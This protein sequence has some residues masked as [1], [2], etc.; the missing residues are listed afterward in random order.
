MSLAM[1]ASMLGNMGEYGASSK[2]SA[3]MPIYA[4]ARKR[5]K[6]D[7]VARGYAAASRSQQVQLQHGAA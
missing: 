2:R 3:T 6:C 5:E 7:G 4:A 1:R